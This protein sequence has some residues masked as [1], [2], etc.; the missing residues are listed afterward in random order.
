MGS[1]LVSHT[2]ALTVGFSGG[3]R[4]TSAYCVRF[5]ENAYVLKH[6]IFLRHRLLLFPPHPHGRGLRLFQGFSCK[7]LVELFPFPL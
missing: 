5:D 7:E 3:S 2:V 1:V 6:R 4:L